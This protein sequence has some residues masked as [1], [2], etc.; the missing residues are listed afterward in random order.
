MNQEKP[1]REAEQ[2]MPYIE[3]TLKELG[4]SYEVRPSGLY[5]P[6]G[7]DRGIY[8]G[9]H[10]MRVLPE[11]Q[12]KQEFKEYSS[13]EPSIELGG[14]VDRAMDEVYLK[15]GPFCNV[16]VE[17][18]HELGHILTEESKNEEEKAFAFQFAWQKAAYKTVGCIR[19][20]AMDSISSRLGELPNNSH[21]HNHRQAFD[22]VKSLQNDGVSPME[23]YQLLLKSLLKP[24]T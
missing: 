4:L 11:D 16:F 8:V 15:E 13:K 5:L 9:N 3:S 17:A 24:K 14:F 12:L 18:G 22:L 21:Y 2:I 7:Q 10:L 19:A 6:K 1:V 23:L 20:L